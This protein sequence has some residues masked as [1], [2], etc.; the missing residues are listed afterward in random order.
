VTTARRRFLVP[1]LTVVV[2]LAILL[3]LGTWQVYRLQ[4]KE[5]ILARIAEAEVVAPV[6]LTA[7]PQPYTKVAVTGRFRF[8]LAA[9]F[10]AEVR[11]TNRGPTMGTYQI[12]PLERDGR[13][14]LLVDRGWVP[15]LREAPLDDPPGEVTVTGYVRPEE[16]ARWFSPTD[17]L[18]TRQFYTLDTDV[19]AAA[20]GLP[21][22]L[23]FTMIALGPISSTVFPAPAQHLPQPSNNHLSY[24][25]TWYGL[26]VALIVIFIVWAR[27]P[28]SP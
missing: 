16:R 21:R 3:G 4:W 11:D 2:M 7:D 8:D 5:A 22:P 15:Q 25:I 26:A 18:A 9:Q 20:V 24:A 10:G 12:V 27:K 28:A 6:P 14:P 1:T 13:P 19:I 23:P 17:D